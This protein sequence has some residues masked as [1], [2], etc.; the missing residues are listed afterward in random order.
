MTTSTAMTT[1]DEPLEG[2]TQWRPPS[3]VL[4]EAQQ[5][6]AELVKVINMKPKPVK[7]NNETYLEFEDWQTC[8]K[9]YGVTAKVESTNFVNYDGVKGF[10]ATAVAVDATGRE[11]SRAEALCL[12]DEENWGMVPKY[13]WQDELDDKGKKIWDEGK[14]RY[15]GKRVQVGES[16]KPLFQ[17]K[18]MAQT[19]ACSKVLRQV[20][21]WVVVL[22]GYRPTPAEEMTGNEQGPEDEREERPQVQQPQRASEKQPELVEMLGPIES[23]KIGKDGAVWFTLDKKILM[24][25]ADLVQDT[26]AVG[27]K[28]HVKA[29]RKSSEKIPEWYFAVEVLKSDPPPQDGGAPPEASAERQAEFVQEL[30]PEADQGTVNLGELMEQGQVKK[31]SDIEPPKPG[32]IGTKRAQRLYTMMNQNKKQTGLTEEIVKKIIAQEPFSIQSLSDLPQ[33]SMAHFEQIMLGEVD[34]K[35]LLEE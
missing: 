34:W 30:D 5:A 3:K 2:L 27:G 15:K 16:P 26:M 1:Y 31:A 22:A 12:N 4:A 32:V 6:A 24:V 23:A 19:R 29:L 9:F 8:A 33:S 7:F 13:E 25:K 17:L 10:E 11:V 21:S 14:K 18:S 35:T 28:M 20:F